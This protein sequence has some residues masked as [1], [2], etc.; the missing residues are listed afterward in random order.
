[1]SVGVAGVLLSILNTSKLGNF[2]KEVVSWGV[3]TLPM[4]AERDTDNRPMAT[5]ILTSNGFRPL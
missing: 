1:M 3:V 4:G 5:C 2:N